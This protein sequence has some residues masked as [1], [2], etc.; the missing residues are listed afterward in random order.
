MIRQ[1]P[2]HMLAVFLILACMQAI[3]MMAG[4]RAQK[5]DIGSA[6]QQPLA[7]TK[8]IP[9]ALGLPTLDGDI[10]EWMGIMDGKN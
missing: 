1:R 6:P 3:P 5:P 8:T 9:R 2:A 4:V 10:S 7:A